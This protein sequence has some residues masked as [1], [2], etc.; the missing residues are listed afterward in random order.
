MLL[1]FNVSILVFYAV[2]VDVLVV[3]AVDFYFCICYSKGLTFI[4][5]AVVDVAVFLS[6][7]NIMYSSENCE[8][9]Y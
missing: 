6:Y 5:L 9:Y 4:V 7:D 1:Y 2:F 3:A 8:S